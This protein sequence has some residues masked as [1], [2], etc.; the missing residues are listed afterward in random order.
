MPGWVKF[1]SATTR[2]VGQFSVG[3]DNVWA[4][5]SNEKVF[6]TAL[7]S[8][9]KAQVP[10]KLHLGPLKDFFERVQETFDIAYLDAT[11][12]ILGGKPLA[13]ALELFRASR[14]QPLAVLI[15][16]FAEVP[17]DDTDRYA[18]VM[19][20]FFRFRYNDVPSVLHHAGVDPAWAQF[21][22][23]HMLDAVRSNLEAVYSDFI[24][25]LL[26]DLARSWIPAARGFRV[27]EK[28]YVS[29]EAPSAIDAAYS[30]G[31]DGSSLEEIIASVGD[32]HLSP[33]AYPLVSFM[34]SMREGDPSEPLI[35]HLGNLPF[36]GRSAEELNKSVALL[37]N[38]SE[39]HWEIAN[40]ELIRAIASPWFDRD[41][42]FTCD[43]P[44][45]R[46]MMQSLLGMYGYPSYVSLRDCLRGSYVA[47]KT[48]MFTDVL[49]LDRCR[50]Y[51][52][53]FPTAAQVPSRFSSHAV[54]VLARC[55]MDRM[56]SSDAFCDSH[57][58]KGSS[59]AGFHK[60]AAAPFHKLEQREYWT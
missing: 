34:R 4:V 28:Q 20:D 56:W 17:S 12:P 2:K 44:F 58:F 46:L 22:S 1:T 54:Q 26:I 35:Q 49:L 59:V 39:G 6:D 41:I 25:R 3:V 9:S 23:D 55:L 37:D 30:P 40:Q 24:T 7:A 18:R 51:F 11:G 21:E 5:E 52:D 45:P 31:K 32:V 38:I 13:P 57:P 36:S 48:R 15:T 29:K 47:K 42:V 16:N 14:L 50:Y 19:T 60:L 43:L 8:L 33:S 27:L 53:W 10:V